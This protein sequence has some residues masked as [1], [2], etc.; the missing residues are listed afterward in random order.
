M[1]IEGIAVLEMGAWQV[2]ATGRWVG[3]WGAIVKENRRGA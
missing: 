2:T 1:G 3:R